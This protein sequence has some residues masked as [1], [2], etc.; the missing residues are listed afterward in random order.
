[1]TE[2]LRYKSLRA[3]HYCHELSSPASSSMTFL[4][5]PLG[6]RFRL[7]S[8]NPHGVESAEECGVAFR[9]CQ[10]DHRV[11]NGRGFL[12]TGRK[13]TS[14]SLGVGT[15]DQNC[16]PD[17]D[18]S[19]LIEPTSYFSLHIG[20]NLLRRTASECVE[21]LLGSH[22]GACGGKNRLLGDLEQSTDAMA[23]ALGKSP[24]RC[25]GLW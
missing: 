19:A 7:A 8:E 12:A 11:R 15:M 21:Y 5:A 2:I 22:A 25:L 6:G 1:M 23:L 4:M 14:R 20:G 16:L 18:A 9:A 17:R 10:L 3:N 24:D 13:D